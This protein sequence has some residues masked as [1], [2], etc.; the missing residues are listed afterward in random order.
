VQYTETHPFSI[1]PKSPQKRTFGPQKRPISPTLNLC[2]AKFLPN[3]SQ[4]TDFN[5]HRVFRPLMVSPS[6][7]AILKLGSKELLT[8]NF[9]TLKP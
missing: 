6:R 5:T 9:E 2:Q 3:T 8:F 4:P 1:A 7:L